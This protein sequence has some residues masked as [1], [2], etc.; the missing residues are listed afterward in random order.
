MTL[1]PGDIII[2]GTPSGIGAGMNPPVFL[3]HGDIIE[4]EIEGIGILRNIVD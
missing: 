4:S 3:K 1:F 2:T